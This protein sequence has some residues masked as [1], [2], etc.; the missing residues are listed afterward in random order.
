M[1]AAIN[2][3]A[4]A[5]VVVPDS[6]TNF[7]WLPEDRLAAL[8]GVGS[9]SDADVVDSRSFGAFLAE[10]GIIVR[11]FGG[12]GVRITVTDE[13]ETDRLLAALGL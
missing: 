8:A 6:Q 4:G 13:A 2:G 1:T 10:K 7:V 11:F 5:E 9:L 3:A 12:E